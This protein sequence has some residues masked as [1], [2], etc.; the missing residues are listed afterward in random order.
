[1][2]PWDM[3]G[4]IS[5]CTDANELWITERGTSFGYNNLVS[6]TLLALQYMLEYL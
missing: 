6:L 4:V 1:M 5:K 3:E 2:A